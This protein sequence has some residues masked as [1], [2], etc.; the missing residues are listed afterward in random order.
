MGVF[1]ILSLGYHITASHPSMVV[2]KLLSLNNSFII[3]SMLP[4]AKLGPDTEALLRN[5]AGRINLK[6]VALM[7]DQIPFEHSFLDVV[8]C[9]EEAAVSLQ[10]RITLRKVESAFLTA[11]PFRSS[12]SYLYSLL[13]EP[14]ITLDRVEKCILKEP[15][16]VSRIFQTVNSA[17]NL[18]RNRIELLGQALA[19]LGIEGIKQVIALLIFANISEK[20]IN[21]K[22]E[23]TVHSKC[24]AFMAEKLA[25][26]RTRDSALIGKIKVAS[27]LHDLGALALE[28]CF[29][30]DWETVSRSAK[31]GQDSR[32]V[33][34]NVFGIEHCELGVFLCKSWSLPR[35]VQDTIELHHSDG[36]WNNDIV[37]ETVALV[38]LFLRKEI[39]RRFMPDYPIEIMRKFTSNAEQKDDEI[40]ADV[41]ETL[42]SLWF[43]FGL[44]N[45]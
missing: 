39:D 17:G 29:P 27:L 20:F 16:L 5:V 45:N 14:D 18:R 44:Q 32:P 35:Y 3:F 37:V 34:K 6:V 42:Q 1:E 33:E 31:M 30:D 10:R 23:T 28:F 21:E 15:L 40:R 26:A 13:D 19:Y 25:S 24:C 43:K 4:F 36:N 12:V 41:I 22:S 38:N 7:G 8:P 2:L 9:S 11:S